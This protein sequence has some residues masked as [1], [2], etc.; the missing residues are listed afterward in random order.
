MKTLAD[1]Y[2]NAELCGYIHLTN[3]WG[4]WV[5]RTHS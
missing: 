1:L 4:G 3:L 2:D 5:H